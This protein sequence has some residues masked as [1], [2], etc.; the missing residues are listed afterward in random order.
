MTA[1]EQVP[2]FEGGWGHAQGPF[3]LKVPAALTDLASMIDRQ[4]IIDV[5][6]CHAWSVDERQWKVMADIYT[7]DLT[8]SGCIAGVTNMETV[9]GKTVFIDWLKSFLE[10]RSDQLRH[11]FLN[12]V[13]TELQPH[14]ATA[15]GYCVLTST[16]PGAATVAAT[17]IYRFSV[18]K[19]GGRWRLSAIYSGLDNSPF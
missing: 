7:D 15:I 17:G 12:V 14:E 3:E 5:I 18:V 4:S 2:A 8:S 16:S 1:A 13:V 10:T 11:N 19:Q 6:A 9:R